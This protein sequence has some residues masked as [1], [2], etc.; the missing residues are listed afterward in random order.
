ML[1]KSR[2]T[3]IHP[4]K[5][6]QLIYNTKNG[7]QVYIHNEESSLNSDAD[8]LDSGG[9]CS[10]IISPVLKKVFCVD[11]ETDEYSDVMLNY[12]KQMFDPTD[13]AFIIMPNNIC[14]FKCV[15]C[16]QQH[17]RRLMSDETISNFITAIKSYHK[18]HGLRHFYAEWF[19]GEPFMTFEIIKKVTDQLVEYFEENDISYHFGAT[20]NGSLLNEKTI[21]YL[22]SRKFDYFQITL[23]GG[24]EMHNST[25]PFL[26]GE[27]S[28]DS[29]CNNLT[30]FKKHKDSNF[31]IAIRVNYNNETFEKIDEL[32]DFINDKL[33]DRFT[34]FFHTIGKW[35][36]ENDDKL[37]V[38]DN[39]LEPYTTL[40][41][42]EHA[43]DKGI[44]PRTNYNFFNPF[45]KMCYAALPY[46]FTL[47]SDGKLRKCNEED[48]EIDKF[49]IV[50]T[51]E[52]GKIELDLSKWGK[53][54][55]PG[56]HADLQQK[57]KECVYLPICFG[58]NCPKS[59]IIN[60]K[61]ACPS[62]I[63]VMSEVL[64]NKLRFKKKQK[65]NIK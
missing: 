21:K 19:G 60:G 40:L 34:V 20:T 50:G 58:Q 1:I 11:S 7:A 39:T 52:N 25:R 47:G 22:L 6:G 53:F 3:V 9:D 44:E 16:Y 31:N 63:C 14:N 24:K 27:G 12:Y 4:D 23:D 62:D 55:L 8:M 17:D 61:N 41:L 36:G 48:E 42:M 57:C 64:L 5:N 38:I 49:N 32:F 2:Y 33:D 15:Y 10:G 51:I 45:R 65:I 26:N 54:V 35:G 28:W 29:I 43:V 46:H 18:E 37:D 13:L 56:G 59:R 30:L